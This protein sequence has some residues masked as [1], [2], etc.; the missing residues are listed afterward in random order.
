MPPPHT[1]PHPTLNLTILVLGQFHPHHFG[2]ITAFCCVID[3]PGKF[4]RP[5]YKQFKPLRTQVGKSGLKL[6]TSRALSEF[7]TNT[8]IDLTHEDTRAW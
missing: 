7:E 3:L 4:K 6:G 2:K 5:Y 1:H 8:T